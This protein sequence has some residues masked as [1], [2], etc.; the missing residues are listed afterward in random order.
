MQDKEILTLYAK[1]EGINTSDSMYNIAAT[2][3]DEQRVNVKIAKD[4]ISMI[5]IGYIY[6]F[7]VE[8]DMNSDRFTMHVLEYKSANDI[9]DIKIKNDV[10]RS[11][12]KH[13]PVD[14][15]HL[16]DSIESYLNK[17]ENK[18]IKDI[19]S[20]MLQRFEKDYYLYPAASRLHHAYVGGL[21][22][23]TLGMLDL[24]NDFI[25]MYDFLDK[26]YVYGLII[27]HDMAKVIEFT[28]IEN[29]EYGL[30][31]QLLGHLVICCNEINKVALSLGYED[32]KEVLL[33]SHGVIAHHGQLAFG[34]AKKPATAEALLVWYLDT[35]D[36]K[37]RTLGDELKKAKIDSFTESIGVL[38]RSKIY[39]HK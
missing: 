11:F 23:H 3:E 37:F 13:A 9:E 25:K 38:E 39:R 5:K 19:T 24:S 12:M 18:I 1:V 22:Y 20:N 2:L 26:D 29:T 34:S 36:S 17:I 28:G 30:K 35:I 8:K 15:H 16:K 21:A 33:L 10:F 4:D 32:T 27:L 7:V 6:E 14:F 31:G